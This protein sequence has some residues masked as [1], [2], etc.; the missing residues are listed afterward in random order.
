LGSRAAHFE[1]LTE[2]KLLPPWVVHEHEARYAFCRERVAGKLVLDCGSGEGRGAQAIA[3]GA[4]R[5]IVALDRSLSSVALART[6]SVTPVAAA[7]ERLPIRGASAGVV[8]ALEMIEHLEDPEAFVA[9]AARTLRPDGMFIC[10]TPNRIVRNPGLALSGKPL[11]PWHLRE[12][13]PEEFEILLR[14]SF[15]RTELYGQV[16]QSKGTTRR[17]ELVSRFASSR[18]GAVLHQLAKFSLVV[19]RSR[20]PYEVRRLAPQSD[21]EFIVAVCS[22]PSHSTASV[23]T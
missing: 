21:Y 9:E 20:G 23:A 15:G 14:R 12:W 3:G 11:N 7:A 2:S 4:P 10:S 17:F 18:A 13:T 19:A 8:V 22:E 16:P 6:A 5:G 1:R